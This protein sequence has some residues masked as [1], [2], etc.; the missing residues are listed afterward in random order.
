MMKSSRIESASL[1]YLCKLVEDTPDVYVMF[2]S[3]K[4]DIKSI[5]IT[6]NYNIQNP[7]NP[8]HTDNHL[9]SLHTI[10]LQSTLFLIHLFVFFDFL[11][12][13]QFFIFFK[14]TPNGHVSFKCFFTWNL[15]KTGDLNNAVSFFICVGSVILRN[16]GK[17][18]REWFLR[19]FCMFGKS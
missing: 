17:P 10:A 14:R 12:F 7:H 2:M 11:L 13:S 4:S 15:R 16:H 3:T 8:H 19:V 5:K 18:L 1:K 6:R 9:K